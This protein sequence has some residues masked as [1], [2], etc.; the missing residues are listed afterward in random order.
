V[1]YKFTFN[2][3]IA[4]ASG[5]TVKDIVVDELVDEDGE[6]YLLFTRSAFSTLTFDRP[7]R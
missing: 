1:T 3:R 6:V 2:G 5:K 7:D 4:I